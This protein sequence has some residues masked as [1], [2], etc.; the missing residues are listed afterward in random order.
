[1]SKFSKTAAAFA[2]VPIVAL[3]GATA[4][5]GTPG[6]LTGGNNLYEVKDL[7]TSG[8]YAKT[9]SP[10]CNDEIEYSMLVNNGGYG[11]LTSVNL[12]ATLPSAGGTSTATATTN[13]GGATGAS[14]SVN[15]TLPSN[16]SQTLVKGSTVLYNG[17]GTA[18]STLP[19]TINTSG[20]N[21]GSLD[22]STYEF[23]NFKVQVSCSTPV[24]PTPVYTCDELTVNTTTD[25]KTVTL[26][27]LKTTATNGATFNNV[28]IN[29]GDNTSAT[30]VS[31]VANVTHTY[32]A[33]GTY[34]I[35]A[36][37]NFTVNG[38]TVTATS[39]AC[40]QKVTF[41]SSSTP[42]P[43]TT[44]TTTPTTTAPT[45]LVNTGAGDTIGIFAAV[46][47]VSAVAYRIV[48]ARRLSRQ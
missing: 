10:A 7:T 31:S 44:T 6:Q 26:S 37:A 13:L 19:D 5:A 40:A 38:K 21:I 8:S 15:V 32:A 41:A 12:T 3:T 23:V 22:G 28:T 4:F 42:T 27:A 1:M 17:N 14:D 9:I 45:Q 11:E 25:N 16:A 36:T 46:S 39:D 29:W 48:I 18:I 2:I 35:T 20:V 24:P 30:T 43:T 47:A 34:T 33:A